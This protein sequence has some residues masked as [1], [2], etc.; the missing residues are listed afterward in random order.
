M[1]IKNVAKKAGKKDL[2]VHIRVDNIEKLIKEGKKWE[3]KNKYQCGGG[4]FWLFG[5]AL[6]IVLSYVKNASIGWAVLH[7]I[8]S[9]IYVVYRL[10]VDYGLFA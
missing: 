6:A 4:G 3:E 5:S 8:I 10:I 1:P 9:W 7:G 2:D